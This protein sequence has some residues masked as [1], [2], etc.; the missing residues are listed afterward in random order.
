MTNFCRTIVLFNNFGSM[1]YGMD[2]KTGEYY[3]PSFLMST[4][5]SEAY[6]S[7]QI[8]VQVSVL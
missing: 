1:A 8:I 2:E 6:F 4:S 7:T 3:R 5:C